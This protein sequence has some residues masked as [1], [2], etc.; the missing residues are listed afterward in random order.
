MA[1]KFETWIVTVPPEQVNAVV[2]E[3]GTFYWE[4]IGTDTVDSTDTSSHLET[5][6][7]KLYS[8]RTSNRTAY[9]KI[10]FRRTL[11]LPEIRK[12]K[13]IEQ[14]YFGLK[15]SIMQLLSMQHGSTLPSDSE[16][17]IGIGWAIPPIL[18]GGAGIACSAGCGD[19]GPVPAIIG[20]LIGGIWGA[21]SFLRRKAVVTFWSQ[22][23]TEYDRMVSELNTLIPANRKVLNVE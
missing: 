14:K 7:G 21:V 23:K 11:D 17:P 1:G 15:A 3:Y 8:V 5:R 13:D 10:S 19:I 12:I 6:G 22:N 4:L 9:T 20:I 2:S 16:P 18:F